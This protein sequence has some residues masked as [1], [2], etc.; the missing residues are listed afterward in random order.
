MAFYSIKL[1][2]LP[3]FPP[4]PP[5]ARLTT[6]IIVPTPAEIGGR[7]TDIVGLIPF[8]GE[9]VEVAEIFYPRHLI[10]RAENAIKDTV[11]DFLLP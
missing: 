6:E 8:V 4:P 10:D 5:G 11:A 2:F 9:V 7:I 3:A 1:P